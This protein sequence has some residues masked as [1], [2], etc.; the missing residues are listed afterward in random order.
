[1][2][3]VEDLIIIGS[4]P[5]G[6]SAAMYA[7]REDFKPLLIS[8]VPGGGQLMLTT[9]V[10]NYPGFPDGI[11]GPDLMDILRRHAEKFGAR[12]I[13]DNVTEV[14]FS[15]R[16]FTVKIGDKE[17]RANCVIVAPGA[18]AKML[19]IESEQRFIG[20]GVSS[21]GTCDGPFYKNR[22]VIVVGGGDTAMEDSL[23]VAKFASSVTIVHRRDSF[24]ASKIMQE[25]VK[26]N[27]KIKIMFNTTV[28]EVLGSEKVTGVRLRNIDTNEVTEMAVDGVF[29]AIGHSPN[30]SFLDGKLKL[31]GQGYIITRDE[32]KTDIDGVFV[33]G[34]V[35]DRIYRQAVTA[36]ASGT[37][38][39]LEARHYL[40]NLK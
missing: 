27:P 16:P 17:Y 32:V 33:A 31:D 18:S 24:R 2:D 23:F 13:D 35:A 19:G 28:D 22:K 12:F 20:R 26:S 4:G 7:A 14:D 39:A 1:M 29:V 8:G 10:E 21:C 34:D 30:T 11:M 6:Y 25:K 36:A 38:A 37:K 15:N 5:A 9:L 40:Q 3:A